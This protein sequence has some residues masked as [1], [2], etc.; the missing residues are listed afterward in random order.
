MS[1]NKPKSSYNS[2]LLSTIVFI[3]SIAVALL[4]GEGFVRAKNASMKSYDIEMWKYA[5]ELKQS[6]DNPIL[7]HEHVPNSE[8]VLQSVS[9]R[10]NKEGMRGEN[11]SSI[12]EGRRVLFIGS[13]I[14]L[15]WGV[16]EVDVLTSVIQDMAKQSGQQME[17]L[18][19]GIGNYNTVRYVELF[20][21]KLAHLNPD[22]IV[23]QYFVNDAESLEAGGGNWFLRNSQLAVTLWI[24]LNRTFNSS[25]EKGLLQH[26]KKVYDHETAGYREMQSSLRDLADYAKK[27]DIRLHLAMTPD[28]HN[29]VDYPFTFIHH[30]IE[31]ISNELGIHYIDL[32]P[33][34]SGYDGKSL[35]AMPG[36]PH[37]NALGH[38]LMAESIYKQL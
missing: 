11:I 24:A 1:S 38:K 16:K 2:M 3:I 27:H 35:W 25:G 23:I 15:G 8:A 4:I 9:I 31:K 17:V 10:I 28:I 34:L 29:L 6:S 19:A 21:T 37:P 7:G 5:K 32:L 22:D 12:K 18:N 30:E 14:T 20:L 26:Y 36:D 13:S 33:V